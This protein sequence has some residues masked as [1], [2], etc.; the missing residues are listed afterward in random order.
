MSC[1]LKARLF[2]RVLAILRC[3]LLVGCYRYIVVAALLLLTS[4]KVVAAVLSHVSETTSTDL[5]S[6]TDDCVI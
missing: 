6:L 2:S 5:I 4:L 1:C 3:L